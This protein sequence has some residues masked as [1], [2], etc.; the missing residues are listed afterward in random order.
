MVAS[1]AALNKTSEAI[2]AAVRAPGTSVAGRTPIA[3]ASFS[4]ARKWS[5]VSLPEAAAEP[6][7]R[8]V[9]ASVRRHS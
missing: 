9:L 5:A 4:S 3:E 7:A 8:N 2:A 6:A 1:S